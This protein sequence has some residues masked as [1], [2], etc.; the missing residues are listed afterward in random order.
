MNGL[1]EACRWMN[2]YLGIVGC[3]CVLW[4]LVPL[5]LDKPRWLDPVPR[6]RILVFFVLAG[7]EMFA[8]IAAG[9]Y[10]GTTPVYWFSA[11]FT[12]LHT[13]TICL[14]VWWP[15]PTRLAT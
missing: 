2:Q 12:V 9:T 8:A 6:H 7:F 14:C 10:N 5:I 11:G 15:H 3:I 4:R 13:A 1:F